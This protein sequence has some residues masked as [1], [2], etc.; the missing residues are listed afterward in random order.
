MHTPFHQTM[1]HGVLVE[2]ERSCTS[3]PEHGGNRNV[4]IPKTNKSHG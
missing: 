2:N 3:L 4:V 1:M